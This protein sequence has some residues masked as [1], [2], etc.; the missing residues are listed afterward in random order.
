MFGDLT[1][2]EVLARLELGLQRMPARRRAIFLAVR[3]DDA[4]YTELAGRMGLTVRQVEREV[5]RALL[6][7]DDAVRGIPP[8]PWWRRW[9]WWITGMDR[10]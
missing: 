3:M 8:V 6:Q 9:L 4:S 1:D 10:P 7:L 2:A 5:A